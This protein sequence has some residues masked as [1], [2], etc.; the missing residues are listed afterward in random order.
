M[1]YVIDS[2]TEVFIVDD[3]EEYLRL[4]P[5]AE[6][7]S[8][9]EMLISAAREYCENRTGRSI[10]VKNITLD[11]GEP[12]S[13]VDL[14]LRLVISVTS[15]KD[16]VTEEDLAYTLSGNKINFTEMPEH[17]A[18]IKY[19]SGYS[20]CPAPLKQAMLMLIAHWYTNREAVFMRGQ[21][22]VSQTVEM[23][24]DA[25]VNQYKEWWF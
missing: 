15:A 18:I 9:L 12:M 23:G 10:A 25:I 3:V 7:D 5:D 16:A 17:A 20:T 11:T 6:E 1:N 14:P 4:N 2:V 19:K 22:T 13:T 24:V 8:L 21:R